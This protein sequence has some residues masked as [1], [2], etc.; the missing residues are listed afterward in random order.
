MVI[1]KN[2]EKLFSRKALSRITFFVLII[3][4]CKILGNYGFLTFVGSVV[5]IVIVVVIFIAYSEYLKNSD[6]YIIINPEIFGLA[7]VVASLCSFYPSTVYFSNSDMDNIDH[8]SENYISEIQ[9]MESFIGKEL[10]GTLSYD[11]RYEILL[12]QAMFGEKAK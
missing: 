3:G 2:M 8:I 5:A 9:K 10:P 11:Q 4:L 12:D 6:V 1:K 7:M